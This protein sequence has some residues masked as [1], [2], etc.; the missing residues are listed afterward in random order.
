M[1]EAS[2]APKDVF[3]LRIAII[4]AGKWFAINVPKIITDCCR[5]GWSRHIPSSGQ[6]R[7]QAD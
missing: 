6:T 3:D 4:G 7:L 5:H 1:G 2:T